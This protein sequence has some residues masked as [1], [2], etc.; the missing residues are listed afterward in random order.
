MTRQPTVDNARIFRAWKAMGGERY[1]SIPAL[2]ERFGCSKATIHDALERERA[3]IAAANNPQ[4]VS[5]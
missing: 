4:P 3:R 5:P 1:G 2:A